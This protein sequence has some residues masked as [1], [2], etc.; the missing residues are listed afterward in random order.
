[1]EEASIEAAR[2]T[3]GEIVDK[4]RLASQPTLITRQGRPAAVV[5]PVAWAE[6][7]S[8]NAE[9]LKNWPDGNEWS[10]DQTP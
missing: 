8:L 6:Y 3:L 4:A 9:A 10:H 7:A 5:V 1:M 2:R